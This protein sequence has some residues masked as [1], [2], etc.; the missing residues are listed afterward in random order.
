M[1]KKDYYELLGVDRTAT[2]EQ[3]KKAYRKLALKYHPD[4][5]PSK[6]AEE[7]FKEISEAYAVLYDD[8]KRQMYNQ[9][10][11]AG[12]DQRYSYE[13]IF[14]GADF[15]DIFRGMGFDVDFGF[16]FDDIFE[17]FFGH[18]TGFTRR[19]QPRRGADL[20]Y[21]IEISLE[22]AY[23]GLETEIQVPRTET[24]E[25]CGGSRAKPGTTLQQCPNCNGTGQQRRSQRTAFGMFT[26]VTTCHQCRGEGTFIKE[27]C[28]TCRGQGTVQKS[29]NIELKIPA[30]IDEGSQLR[31][32]G[33]GEAGGSGASTGDL[34]VVIHLKPHPQFK[35]QGADLYVTKEISVPLAALGGK[36]EVE[37]FNGVESLRIPEGTQNGEVFKLKHHGMPYLNRRGQ[38]DLLVEVHVVTP[39]NL[40]KKAKKLLE[41]L[42]DELPPNHDRK[43]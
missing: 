32:T 38:G 15:S 33:E 20:R 14:R 29:R 2:K 13:D 36:I 21:D 23:R 40:S 12:I 16:G 39:R 5:N 34:Y 28:P 4:K 42:Q 43:F 11:H 9:F 22:E 37:T 41:E 24:C 3:I 17:R 8:E 31:L 7:K 30:G 6:E 35:R 19:S 10:G 27:P 26:Q 25:T 18:R 1:N